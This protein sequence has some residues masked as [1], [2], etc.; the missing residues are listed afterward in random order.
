MPPAT[1]FSEIIL[2]TKA[3]S[4]VVTDNFA[5]G[6]LIK[7]PAACTPRISMMRSR[8]SSAETFGRS[9]PC[10]V[11]VRLSPTEP[12]LKTSPLPTEAYF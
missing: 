8:R 7:M 6:R 3:T 11:P 2:S 4:Q 5:A 9:S 1:I 12:G 10:C